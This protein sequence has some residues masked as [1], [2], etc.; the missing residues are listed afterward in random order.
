MGVEAWNLNLDGLHGGIN[1]ANMYL[2]ICFQNTA[3]KF[4]GI[5]IT[6]PKEC[7]FFLH[8]A[9]KSLFSHD[10]YICVIKITL[11]KYTEILI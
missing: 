1:N 6:K 9:E 8:A 11:V 4:T 5:F 7:L 3:V 10:T 2:P